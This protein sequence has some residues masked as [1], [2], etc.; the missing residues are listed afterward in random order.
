MRDGTL[1][2]GGSP[3]EKY[4]DNQAHNSQESRRQRKDSNTTRTWQRLCAGPCS[5]GHSNRGVCDQQHPKHRQNN[6]PLQYYDISPPLKVSKNHLVSRSERGHTGGLD[7]PHRDGVPQSEMLL[8]LVPRWQVAA[9]RC[10]S[11]LRDSVSIL[12]LHTL[13]H[14]LCTRTAAKPLLG[15][16]LSA[17]ASG[18]SGLEPLPLWPAGG[19]W[20]T[21]TIAPSGT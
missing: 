7:L 3:P 9:S 15:K 14:K 19:N 1:P 8:R 2:T 20:L 18:G 10:I 21:P 11:V 12:C 5:L 13:P 4:S 17:S 6:D 16:L